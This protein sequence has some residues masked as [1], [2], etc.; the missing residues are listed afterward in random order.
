MDKILGRKKMNKEEFLEIF[1]KAIDSNIQAYDQHELN[2]R[3]TPFLY[4]VV[5]HLFD[6]EAD[7]LT[8]T[9]IYLPEGTEFSEDFPH[10]NTRFEYLVYFGEGFEQILEETQ[11]YILPG[12]TTCGIVV[13][14]EG[15][16]YDLILVGI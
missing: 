3:F 12:K 2:G 5:C 8:P 15:S 13:Y 7:N 6:E 4:D 11:F 9:V 10:P 14:P 1:N 16:P